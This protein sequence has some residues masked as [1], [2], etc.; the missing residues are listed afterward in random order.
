MEGLP[1]INFTN[2]QKLVEQTRDIYETQ[3]KMEFPGEAS[4]QNAQVKKEN[5]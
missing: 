3:Y 5:L 1:G 2:I 4:F